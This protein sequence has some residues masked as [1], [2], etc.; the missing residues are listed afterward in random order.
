MIVSVKWLQDF[1][2][3]PVPVEELAKR[4]TMAGLEVEGIERRYESLDRVVTAR[5]EAIEKHPKADRLHLCRVFDGANQ[6]R[7]VCGAPNLEP[8]RIVPLA[9]PGTTLPG[10]MKLKETKIRGELS[11]GML[12]SRK[13]LEMGEDAGG[14]WLLDSDL[15][16]GVPVAEALGL[17]DTVFEIGITPN[18]GDCLS[19]LGVARETAAACGGRVKVPDLR[20]NES[21]PPI[22]EVTSVTIEAPAGCPRYTARWIDGVKIGPSPAWLRHRLESVGLRSINNIVDVTNFVMMEMGQPLHAFDF[23]RLRGGRIVVKWAQAGENFSTLDGEQRTLF[24]D[25]LMICDGA[26]PVAVAGIMGGLKSE[27]EDSTTRVLIESAYFDPRSIRR[28]SK[29]LGLNTE[30]AYRF[31]RGVDYGGTVRALDRAAQLML[32]VAGGKLAQGAIDQYPAPIEP[33]AIRLRVDRINRFLGLQLSASE[34]AEKL[35]SIEMRVEQRGDTEFEV[36]PPTYRQDLTR[37]VDLAEEVVRLVGYDRVPVTHPEARLQAEPIDPHWRARRETRELL[38]SLGLFETL[39]YSFIAR[40]L[41]ENLQL[42]ESDP[43]LRPVPLLNPLS[44]EQAVMRTSL[45]PGILNTAARNI[46]FGNTDLKLFELSKVFLPQKG[47]SLPL[48]QFDLVGLMAGRRDSR[49]L[50]GGDEMVGYEDIKGALEAI[51]DRFHLDRVDFAPDQIPAYLE[52]TE[53]ARVLVDGEPIGCLGRV[54]CE[55]EERMDFKNPVYLFELNFDRVFAK[56]GRPA[57]FQPLPRFPAVTRDIALILED[58]IAVRD[59][60]NFIQS[61]PQPLI[62]AVD[63]FDIYSGKQVAAG[64]K[65]I[66]YRVIYRAAN[67]NLTDEE[68]NQIHQELTDQVLTAFDAVLR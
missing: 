48:E 49:L 59:P 5:I 14:I 9:L 10:G 1:V 28:S 42:E 50:Y 54:C 43:R 32:E 27:I 6:H 33:Q 64:K 41:L 68:V 51:L 39:T 24:D 3:C 66:G 16:L 47:A 55:V 26:G 12:C 57:K 34:V 36:T 7:V 30:S 46:D 17:A 19:I 37:E 22:D 23:D 18:R 4:L 38:K 25:T 62:E 45:V 40:S 60:L 65:S 29:K 2:D 67:R 21:G 11:Q 52:P 56:Q 31:E 13:E 15:P 63:I 35:R 8:G 61:Q 44:E 20:L 58:T 53:S